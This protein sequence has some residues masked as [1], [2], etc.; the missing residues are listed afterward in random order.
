MYDLRFYKLIREVTTGELAEYLGA[1]LV[2]NPDLSIVS[3]A[4]PQTAE[5]G[6]VC[7]LDRETEEGQGISERATACI[8]SP[9][10]ADTLPEMVTRIVV[11][12]PRKAFALATERFLQA[13]ETGMPILGRR[14]LPVLRS[15]SPVR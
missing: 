6:A 13:R 15:C 11:D 4:P 3:I 14:K 10:L 5:A 7:Y 12:A 9:G 8:V 1:E 2:G